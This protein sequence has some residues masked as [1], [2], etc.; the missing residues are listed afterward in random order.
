MYGETAVYQYDR[1]VWWNGSGVSMTT[2]GSTLPMAGFHEELTP[3]KF[4]VCNKVHNM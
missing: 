2:M 4:S 3:F 1:G